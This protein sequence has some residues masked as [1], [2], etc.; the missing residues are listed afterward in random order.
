MQKPNIWTIAEKKTFMPMSNNI[1]DKSIS[2]KL[3]WTLRRCIFQVDVLCMQKLT[4]LSANC[5]YDVFFMLK[6]HCKIMV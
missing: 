2:K 6:A 3:V 5:T 4:S 1:I